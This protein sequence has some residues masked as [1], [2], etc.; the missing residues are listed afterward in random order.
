M[1]A[2]GRVQIRSGESAWTKA[3]TGEME[4]F[5]E[6]HWHLNVH[7]KICLGNDLKGSETHLKIIEFST[8]GVRPYNLHFNKHPRRF[9]CRCC[10]DNS[11]WDIL[12]Q[13][14]LV[15]DWVWR[16]EREKGCISVPL[17]WHL[18]PQFLLIT[19]WFSSG[20]CLFPYTRSMWFV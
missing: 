10:T 9:W 14:S 4:S 18:C 1:E 20:K 16:W 13:T 3:A 8:S 6:W 15:M 5:G 11:L 7:F 12:G 2:T 19:V 17:P